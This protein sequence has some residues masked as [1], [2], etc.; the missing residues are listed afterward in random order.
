MRL[1][2]LTR[3]KD[4]IQDPHV[5]FDSLIDFLIV[6]TSARIQT[7]LNRQLEWAQR[8]EYFNLGRAKYW[9]DAYPID[10]SSG[11]EPVVTI[12]TTVQTVDEDYYVWE[13]K[14]LIEFYSPS[15]YMKP[16]ELKIVWYGGYQVIDDSSD[17]DGALDVP[18]ELSLAAC[19]QVAYTF[20]RRGDLGINYIQLP[21]GAFAANKTL[22]FLPDVQAVI[23]QYRNIPMGEP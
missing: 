15:V 6:T 4:F 10:M 3:V 23:N 22:P 12:G 1:T 19:M 14:G 9:L 13:N 8:T 16:K 5:K 18:E 11:Y 2:T 21:N 17:D 20:K 7:A